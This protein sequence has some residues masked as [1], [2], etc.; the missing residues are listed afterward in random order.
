VLNTIPIIH[1]HGSLGPL[2]WEDAEG[3][4]YQPSSSSDIRLLAKSIKV[5]HEGGAANDP[6]FKRAHDLISSAQRLVFLGFGYHPTNLT[7]LLQNTTFEPRLE[8]FG[9][10]KGFTPLEA[11]GVA[12]RINAFTKKSFNDPPIRSEGDLEMDIKAF[13]RHRVDLK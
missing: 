13:L 3:R 5:I 2:P 12:A 11:N 4:H 10:L 7:R 8:V 9:S 6:D 1:L